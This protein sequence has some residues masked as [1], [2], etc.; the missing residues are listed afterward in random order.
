MKRPFAPT[1]HH[2]PDLDRVEAYWRGLLRGSAEIP[3]WDDF[4]P[5][6]LPDLANRLFLIGVYPK[7]ER[8]RFD[9]VGA[10][11]RGS[12]H[13]D[14]EGLFADETPPVTPFE[15]LIPQCAAT[16]EASAPTLYRHEPDGGRSYRRL[17]LPMWGDGRLSMLLGAIDWN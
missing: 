10:D 16:T 12:G 2:S 4:N 14:L 3:F 6:E 13:H 17:I 8:Y 9:Q 1:R 11:L 7:P 5:M 15:F